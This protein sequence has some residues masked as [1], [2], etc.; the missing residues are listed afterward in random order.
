MHEESRAIIDF[1]GTVKW[2]ISLV[3]AG[4]GSLL[5]ILFTASFRSLHNFRKEIKQRM[6]DFFM[7]QEN[8]LESIRDRLLTLENCEK[9]SEKN[10]V[11]LKGKIEKIEEICERNHYWNGIDRRGK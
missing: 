6:D 10:D 8:S 7:Q 2:V 4:T 3:V 9:E 11:E 5:G 1:V